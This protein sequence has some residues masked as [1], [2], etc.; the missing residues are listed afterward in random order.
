MVSI[1]A[2]SITKD[3][4]IDGERKTVVQG[5]SREFHSGL[6]YCF[7]GESGSGKS[8]IL[9]ML[10]LLSRPT[11]GR[12]LF[13]GKEYINDKEKSIF[14]RENIGWVLQNNN[15]IES[16]SVENNI[17]VGMPGVSDREKILELLEKF[18]LKDSIDKKG[19]FLSGGESQRV[20]F[21]RAIIK[22][23]KILILDEFTSGLDEES[24][25][26]LISTLKDITY[27]RNLI[28][29]VASHS[30]RV[31][32]VADCLIEVDSRAS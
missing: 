24:E 22:D 8:T 15:L 32:E 6:I 27:G 18:S 9:K 31:K 5:F 21:V 2:E 11:S 13:G 25:N 14:L 19:S 1:V 12:I 17:R 10:G 20:A 7:C 23:P 26:V 29:L 30:S 28:T 16:L 4:R 3:Y